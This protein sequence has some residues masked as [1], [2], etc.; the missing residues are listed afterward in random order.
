[1]RIAWKPL[2]WGLFTVVLLAML[3]SVLVARRLWSETLQQHGIAMLE[4][5]GLDISLRGLSVRRLTLTQSQPTG[6]TVLRARNLA[7]AWRW[8]EPGAG[9]SPGLR[10]L[11]AGYVELERH[12]TTGKQPAPLQVMP[13]PPVLPAWLPS[14]IAVRRF[15]VILPCAAGR[16]PLT[17]TLSISSG[18]T[19]APAASASGPPTGQRLPIAAHVELE[20]EGH[21]LAVAA[22]LDGSWSDDLQ[23]GA[24]L[25][26]DGS[27]Y[28]LSADSAYRQHRERGLA[29]WRGSVEIPDLPRAN[30]LLAWMQMWWSIPQ[31]WP[32]QPQAASARGSWQLQGPT[33]GRFLT[34]ATGSVSASVRVPQP[35]PLPRLGAIS[36]D[37]DIAVGIDRS[38]WQ[39]ESL[40]ADL[41]LHHPAAWIEE[42]PEPLRLDSLTLSVRSAEAIVPSAPNSP[43]VKTA[44]GRALLPLDVALDSRAGAN[45]ALR[46]H[47]AVATAA[48]WMVQLGP[49]RLRAA[50]P[51]L[52]VAGWTLRQPRLQMDLSGWLDTEGAVLRTGEPTVVEI[53]GLEAD[54]GAMPATEG[55]VLLKGLRADLAKMEL[56]ARYRPGQGVLEELSVSGSL[57]LRAKQIKHPQL[58]A[59]PWRF[60]GELHSDLARTVLSGAL[61]AHSGTTVN[62]ELDF[63][64]RGLLRLDGKMQVSGEDEAAALSRVLTAWP[65]LLTVSGGSVSAT[66]VYAQAQNSP[67]RLTGKLVFADWSG[68]YDR[69]AWSGM[70]G[71]VALLLEDGHI[72]AATPKLT[73]SEVNPGLPLG[74]VLVAGRYRAPLTQPAAGQLTLQQASAGALGGEVRVRPGNW[75]LVRTPVTIPVEI[76]R[77]S[78][79]RLLQLYPTEGLSGTGIL[80]GTVPVLFDPASGIQVEAGRID[81]LQPGGRLRLSAERLQALASQSNAMKLVAQALEDF[82]YSV[83]DSA[84]DYDQDGTLVL[85][86]HLVGSSPN[87]DQGQSLVLNI[88]LEENIPALLT[89]LQLSGR[90]SDAVTDRVK[91]LLQERGRESIELLQ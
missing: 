22:T 68:V 67:A 81:A 4:W 13:W 8:R 64:Y 46:S 9:W 84:I 48:P 17:G 45:I 63:P 85:K 31:Q 24:K 32:G 42:V 86:L 37:L 50:L 47:L 54:S 56:E 14:T 74:P 52:E 53:D 2:G 6:D 5:Q 62:V 75:N 70:N 77:L 58:L 57:G 88:N 59:Q 89:T 27:R 90:V 1:M 21:R 87:V 79:A 35:W 91:K 60:N 83:L 82:R 71:A 69:T 66:A 25:T 73:V 34:R 76:E 72:S 43:T 30:W 38:R 3:S 7:V 40:R 29:S 78:L 55:D 12:T 19:A 33:D 65:P 51:K 39:P 80:S 15:R 10:A 23:F 16:C 44:A 49:T 36:G 28:L 41:E 61:R 11:T 26:L 18:Q 20:H